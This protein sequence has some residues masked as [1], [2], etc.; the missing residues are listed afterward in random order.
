[1]I[2]ISRNPNQSGMTLVELLIAL[3]ITGLL[4]TVIVGFSTDKL[5]DSALQGAKNDLLTNA[6]TGLNRVTNDIRLANSADDQNRW[7]DNNAPGAPGDL[8]SWNSSASVLILAI[9]AQDSSGNILFDD[10]HDYVSAKN[11]SIYYVSNGT[12]WRRTLA[13][14]KT[15]N[16][17]T[18]SCPS[19]TANA[20]CPAD[21]RV[22]DDVSDFQVTYY[23][24]SDQQVDPSSA[25]SIKLQVTLTRHVYGQNITVSYTTRMVFRNG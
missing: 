20:T 22:L 19:S 14:P 4:M 21:R 3:V 9:A 12:L 10:A 23:D 6:Q 8:Y 25:R 2:R 1:M 16:A 13:A 11:N 17:A 5:R 18:T 24:G 7:S 15:G